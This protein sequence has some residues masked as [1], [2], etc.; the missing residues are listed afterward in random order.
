MAP[1]F[2]M[3]APRSFSVSVAEPELLSNQNPPFSPSVLYRYASVLEA[4]KTPP[5]KSPARIQEEEFMSRVIRP[6][7]TN[8]KIERYLSKT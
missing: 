6:K 3:L 8:I 4:A 5:R 1:L 2:R 7:S